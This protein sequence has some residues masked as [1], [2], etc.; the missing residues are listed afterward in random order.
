MV[1]HSDRFYL[2]RIYLATVL[3]VLILGLSYLLAR[4]GVISV[5]DLLLLC[6]SSTGAQLCFVYGRLYSVCGPLRPP[7]EGVYTVGG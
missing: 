3:A 6:K 7:Y 2:L 4:V 1:N 5:I